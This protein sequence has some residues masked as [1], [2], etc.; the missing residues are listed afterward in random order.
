MRGRLSLGTA[1]TDPQSPWPRRCRD[2]P[3]ESSRAASRRTAS[4]RRDCPRPPARSRG[5][6][7]YGSHTARV[8]WARPAVNDASCGAPPSKRRLAASRVDDWLDSAGARTRSSPCTPNHLTPALGRWR[9]ARRAA[10][11]PDTVP[12]AS[13]SMAQYAPTACCDRTRRNARPG[14]FPWSS[15]RSTP[16]TTAP[17]AMPRAWGVGLHRR[18]EARGPRCPYEPC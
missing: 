11:L 1:D 13:P 8:L 5:L 18:Y 17:A 10:G 7:G 3:V 9:N 6:A 4:A 16:A 14:V 2:R 12:P 15:A